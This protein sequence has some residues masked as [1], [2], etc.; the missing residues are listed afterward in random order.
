MPEPTPLSVEFPL[1]GIAVDCEL[2]QQPPGTTPD[3]TNVRG[4]DSILHRMR[5]GSRPGIE[6]YPT[7]QLP[8]G[9]HVVQFLGQ[10]VV[11]DPDYLLS[12]FED[13]QPDFVTDPSTNNGGTRNPTGRKINPTG[14]GVQTNR[15]R[16][17]NPRRRVSVVASAAIQDNG[18]NVTITATLTKQNVNTIVAGATITLNTKPPGR[19]GDGQTTTT[20]G[21][22]VGSFVVSETDFDDEVLYYVS[23]EYTVP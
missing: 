11:L 20:N 10:L 17:S 13:F 23:N 8:S 4:R 5:G 2:G 16:P 15:N 22:G 14:S 1:R 21:S 12:T 9:S 18:S 19:N 3:A 6:K 7:Q